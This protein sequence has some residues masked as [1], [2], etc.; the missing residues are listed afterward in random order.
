MSSWFDQLDLSSLQDQLTKSVNEAQSLIGNVNNL[1]I[2]NFDGMAVQEEEDLKLEE[3]EEDD[4][5][6]EEE[7]V[8]EDVQTPAIY[9][10]SI[11]LFEDVAPI[12]EDS[13]IASS[14]YINKPKLK[15]IV[16]KLNYTDEDRDD[17]SFK[18]VDIPDE[19]VHSSITV[20]HQLVDTQR[21]S[22]ENTQAD[23]GDRL[24]AMTPTHEDDVETLESLRTPSQDQFHQTVDSTLSTHRHNKHDDLDDNDNDNDN[25]STGSRSSQ[26]T[27]AATTHEADSNSG[28]SGGS[29]GSRE[30]R[31]SSGG[32][33]REERER[34]DYKNGKGAKQ[35]TIDAKIT[36]LE[37][38]STDSTPTTTTS[39]SNNVIKQSVSS[40]A[41]TTN[42]NKSK[43]AFQSTVGIASVERVRAAP[44]VSTPIFEYIL[45]EKKT[46]SSPRPII[47]PAAPSTS[48]Y[49]DNTI[50]N[51][52][53]RD[54]A[55]EAKP[56]KTKKAKE[57]PVR[58]ALDFWGT[59]SNRKTLKFAPA[60]GTGG[61]TADGSTGHGEAESGASGASAAGRNNISIGLLS[62]VY[63]VEE[64]E[65]EE[66]EV[67]GTTADVE[68]S[69]SHSHLASTSSEALDRVPFSSS[70]SSSSVHSTPLPPPTSTTSS[71]LYSSVMN[72]IAMTTGKSTPSTD[73]TTLSHNQSP[74]P[75]AE[76]LFSFFDNVDSEVDLENDPVQLKVRANRALPEATNLSNAA[77]MMNR[78]YASAAQTYTGNVLRPSV[79]TGGELGSVGNPTIYQ[80]FT[81][82]VSGEGPVLPTSISISGGSSS[83]GNTPSSSG[84]SPRGTTTS[85]SNNNT[86]TSETSSASES[87]PVISRRAALQTL[88]LNYAKQL[89][90]FVWDH[91]FTTEGISVITGI[92]LFYSYYKFQRYGTDAGDR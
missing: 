6:E 34:S 54:T 74:A 18:I 77:A 27:S 90:L 37:P 46:A 21:H 45:P 14:A 67:T 5:E 62:D 40:S 86:T 3:N 20:K 88:L 79:A 78:L 10:P 23:F 85:I 33:Q 51:N 61:A 55:R 80:I 50:N 38:K 16:R 39:D 91:M 92:L 36:L 56:K 65:E 64:E 59:S 48:I 22:L 2:L 25:H 7:D 4:D 24:N 72:S 49:R 15:S 9:N 11:S 8:Y 69:Q 19:T 29:G 52:T 35:T 13:F 75:H 57:K 44:A 82:I 71:S 12:V 42:L 53:S 30:V 58:G 41:T 31:Q 89:L 68:Q 32:E 17:V 47:T 1:D 26:V 43:Q 28:S 73:T 60:A 76:S 81:T 63:G 70:S 87:A 84:G 83:N 66:V